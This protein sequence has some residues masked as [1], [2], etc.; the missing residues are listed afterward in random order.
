MR[1]S[2]PYEG[3]LGEVGSCRKNVRGKENSMSNGQRYHG[4][5]EEL[6]DVCIMICSIGLFVVN[7]SLVCMNK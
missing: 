1:R 5:L 4:L 6:G 2:W 3:G 7:L